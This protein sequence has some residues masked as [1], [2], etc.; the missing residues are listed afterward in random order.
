MQS[1]KNSV[2]EEYERKISE[3]K[4][5]IRIL[6]QSQDIFNKSRSLELDYSIYKT[7]EKNIL[8]EQNNM[9]ME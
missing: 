3:L 4:D 6:Q 5:Q 2:S 8:R 9:L 1:I 7:E